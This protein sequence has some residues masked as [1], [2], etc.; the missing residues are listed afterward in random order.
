VRFD[1]HQKKATIFYFFVRD[2]GLPAEFG[3]ADFKPIEIDPIMNDPHTV[4]FGIADADGGLDE[5][6]K[7]G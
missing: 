3:A 2:P 7:I 1:H 5:F 6:I 4:N